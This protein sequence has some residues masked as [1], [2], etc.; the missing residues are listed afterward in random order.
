MGYLLEAYDDRER[1]AYRQEMGAAIVAER[2][3]LAAAE[4][5]LLDALE[6][7]ARRKQG[8]LN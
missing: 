2:S 4:S 8:R 1:V 6:V 7:R 3:T 5:L